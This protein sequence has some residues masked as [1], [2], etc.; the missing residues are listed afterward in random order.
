MKNDHDLFIEFYEQF[1]NKLF[2]YLMYRLNFDKELS[3]DLLMDIVLKA[4]EKFGSYKEKKGSFKN[5]IFTI[6]HNHL[7]NY[8]RDQNKKKTVDIES[9][10]IDKEILTDYEVKDRVD[11]K[12]EM[13]RVKKIFSIMSESNVELLILKY[14]HEFDNKEI[15][16][17]LKK[18]EG[19][20][21]TNLSRAVSQF[22]ELYIKMYNR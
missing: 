7:L 4:Y 12:I 18:K 17:I 11:A 1:K 8:W 10:A 2:T 19:A 16:K 15:S 5:W 14:I 3:E 6:A 9:V 22:K 21:R 13:D 20:V